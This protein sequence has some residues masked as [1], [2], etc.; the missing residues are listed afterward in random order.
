[1]CHDH[2]TDISSTDACIDLRHCDV[3]AEHDADV[4]I[5]TGLCVHTLRY[6]DHEIAAATTESLPNERKQCA[7]L[8]PGLNVKSK[9]NNF[10]SRNKSFKNMKDK[11]AVLAD[12]ALVNTAFERQ[13]CLS[14]LS[15]MHDGGLV[16]GC[17][18]MDHANILSICQYMLCSQH[19]RDSFHKE[20]VKLASRVR[21]SFMKHVRIVK[22]TR[23]PDEP[24]QVLSIIGSVAQ[25]LYN[26]RLFA[27]ENDECNQQQSLDE[28]R[29]RSAVQAALIISNFINKAHT[30]IKNFMYNVSP[31]TF[32]IG[33]L[34]LL[35][36]GLTAH[37]IVVLPQ[38]SILAHILPSE[39]LL[40]EFFQVKC[41]CITEV[42]NII[43]LQVRMLHMNDLVAIQHTP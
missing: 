19:T 30:I 38:Y 26:Y 22:T 28:T 34:Y 40:H 31:K 6:S 17:S 9:N 37:H 32:V 42:E 23:P 18:V 41:K 14:G 13:P 36:V 20:R 27:T 24:V 16:E 7:H 43:K 12:K 2:N 33:V 8:Q 25:D 11:K 29:T 5:V 1:V 10:K 39:N 4:C 15:L 21:S 3:S 35:R